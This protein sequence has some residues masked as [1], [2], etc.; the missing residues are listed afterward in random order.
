MS[1]I[2][3]YGFFFNS[4]TDLTDGAGNYGGSNFKIPAFLDTVMLDN[5][6]GN[7]VSGDFIL[8]KNGD[9][10]YALILG[11]EREILAEP[12][13]YFRL[14]IENGNAS[15]L[16]YS[17]Q[18]GFRD[19]GRTGNIEISESSATITTSSNNSSVTISEISSS[20]TISLGEEK[21]EHLDGMTAFES[22]A[23]TSS[24]FADAGSNKT[25]DFKEIQFID[26]FGSGTFGSSLDIYGDTLAIGNRASDEVYI[27]NKKSDHWELA[28]TLRAEDTQK[29]DGFGCSV[30]LRD[31]ILIIGAFYV[32][33]E[34][35]TNQGTVYI[36]TKEKDKWRQ[37][38]KLI[39]G[40]GGSGDLFGHSLDIYD[41]IIVIGA[42]HQT[43]NGNKHQGSVYIYELS[44]TQWILSNKVFMTYG[45]GITDGY[46][47]FG[48]S[49]SIDANKLVIGA[50]GMGGR[51]IGK[52]LVYKRNSDGSFKNQIYQT[53][54]ANDAFAEDMFGF[55]VQIFDNKLFVSAI[56]KN[57][58]KG[59]IQVFE[60][61][62]DGKFR[63]YGNIISSDIMPKSQF[64]HAFIVTNEFI[65]VGSK[66]DSLGIENNIGQG[67]VYIF[68]NGSSS[69]R[70]IMKL[71][72]LKG[73]AGH[74]FG[75]VLGYDSGQIIITA[76]GAGK[77]GNGAVY[78]YE[79]VGG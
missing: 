65:I 36:F 2:Y 63:Y 73:K 35:K 12:G 54:S 28:Q 50:P 37:K 56:G 43:I 20:K 70:Q 58:Q 57:G 29:N 41:N 21:A 23:S 3:P 11:E 15:N 59:A 62:S 69:Y 1:K 31:N 30:V 10:R 46:D 9:K 25:L 48:Y 19:A 60:E 24:E 32:D 49:I 4:S 14:L 55:G 68:E 27:Y 7:I 6:S 5:L 78:L 66:N 51:N 40:D 64:S 53:I 75:S 45:A 79:E 22:I 76:S 26:N 77:H 38:Q 72:A 74:H 42:P 17:Y 34:D 16:L 67:S 8:E 44:G 71:I 33:V 13:D 52:V 18:L 61:N 47:K 39:A